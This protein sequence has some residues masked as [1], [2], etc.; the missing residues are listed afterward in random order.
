MIADVSTMWLKAQIFEQ[1]IAFV[2]IGQEIEAKIA[3][4]P[5]RTFTARIANIGSASDLTTRRIMVRSE[6]G[7]PDGALKSE[8][9]A[10]FKIGV[11]APSVAP[12][13]ADSCSDPRKRPCD[14]VG[15]NRTDAVQAS[16]GGDWD[17]A[18]RPNSDPPRTRCR[19]T[20]D[21]ARGDLC[22]QR[23]ASMTLRAGAFRA[24]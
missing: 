21:L 17:R 2:Q 24:A 1:D 4:A 20:G 8:M 6:I 16:R 10:T 3:A 5:N 14:S 18:E 12:S 15:A 23:M 13:R 7:N 19:R 9:C 11:A 22:R